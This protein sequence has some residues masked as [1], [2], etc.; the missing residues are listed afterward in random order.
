MSGAARSASPAARRQ[1]GQRFLSQA[2]VVAKDVA[3][4]DRLQAKLE[5]MMSEQMPSVVGR[6][7][8][9]ELGPPVARRCNTG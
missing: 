5:K 3:A 6:V 4:R 1:A 7:S 8:P 9:L 2:V